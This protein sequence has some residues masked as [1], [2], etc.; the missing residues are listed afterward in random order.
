[1]G[2]FDDLQHV[3]PFDETFRRAVE[4]KSVIGTT[5]THIKS[6]SAL[7]CISNHLEAVTNHNED[8]LHTPQLPYFSI[9]GSDEKDIAKE[10]KSLV[11]TGEIESN[12]KLRE[13]DNAV[14]VITE[15]SPRVLDT[16]T[17]QESPVIV[18]NEVNTPTVNA[19]KNVIILPVLQSAP[20]CDIPAKKLKSILPV[21]MQAQPQFVQIISA[22]EDYDDDDVAKTPRTKPLKKL[23]PKIE[24]TQPPEINPVKEKLKEALLKTK[25][26]TIST[27]NGETVVANQCVNKYS[28]TQFTNTKLLQVPV[29]TEINQYQLHSNKTT[30]KTNKTKDRGKDDKVFE[31]NRAAAQRYRNKLKNM[32]NEIQ[33][34]NTDLMTENKRLKAEL[35]ALKILLLAHQDCS[36]SRSLALGNS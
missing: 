1:M 26:N 18:N 17:S 29:D 24:I 34:Q 15:T 33:Q 30:N 3:N 2:L 4:S 13:V 19:V 8:T 12:F 21:Q 23:C 35:K 31:R 32:H 11:S 10:K 16:K 20:V 36:V 22:H 9:T 5:D 27:A 25:L 6:T 28:E 7:F 14:S